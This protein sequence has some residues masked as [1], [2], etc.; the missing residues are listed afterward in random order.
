MMS[1]QAR[2][3]EMQ[4]IAR[5]ATNC[6]SALVCSGRSDNRVG[7]RVGHMAAEHPGNLTNFSHQLIELIRIE[8]LLAVAERAIRIGMHLDDEAVGSDGDRGA[9]QW[10]DL[11]ALA[12]AVAGIDDDGQVAQTLYGR[13]H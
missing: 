5:L 6:S 7:H 10:R 9:R 4:S 1:W 13:H 11:V 12:G 2:E 3:A 8:R